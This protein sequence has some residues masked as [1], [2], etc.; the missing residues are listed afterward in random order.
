MRNVGDA[1][2]V[3]RQVLVV[4]P[5]PA[6]PKGARKKIDELIVMRNYLSHYSGRAKRALQRVYTDTYMLSTFRRPGEFLYADTRPGGQI[7]FGSYLKALA[8]ASI[9][10]RKDLGIAS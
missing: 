6:I 7:R 1:R 5:F 10:M 4:N 9:A 3:A 2:R 8:D